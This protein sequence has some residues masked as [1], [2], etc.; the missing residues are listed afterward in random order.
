MFYSTP[1]KKLKPLR[2]SCNQRNQPR[3]IDII[4]GNEHLEEINNNII[5]DEH[6]EEIDIIVPNNLVIVPNNLEVDE[7]VEEI[8]IIV[9]NNLEVDEHVEEI[10]I[11]EPN[12]L[13]VDNFNVEVDYFEGLDLHSDVAKDVDDNDENDID[14]EELVWD[15]DVCR[16]LTTLG[17]YDYL[18]LIEKK[19]SS[20]KTLLTR[21]SHFLD[22]THKFTYDGKPL[23]DAM[24]KDWLTKFVKTG[25]KVLFDFVKYLGEVKCFLPSTIQSYLDDI[26]TVSTWFVMFCKESKCGNEDI[27]GVHHSIHAL[28]R[29]QSKKVWRIMLSELFNNIYVLILEQ[30]TSEHSQVH[31]EFGGEEM[32]SR[33]EH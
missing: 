11:I 17:L 26:K 7:H 3:I 10:D 14:Q 30:E 16:V 13:E 28:R 19:E 24:V 22:W 12:N 18:K 21:V 6:L 8:D 9:P 23:K 33:R 27:N 4:I 20:R 31:A 1:R 25:F 5:V 29:I 15:E 2:R 32:S